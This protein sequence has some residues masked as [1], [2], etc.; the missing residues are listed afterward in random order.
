VVVCGRVADPSL[1]VGPIMAHYGGHWDEWDRLGRATMAGHLLECGAQVTGGYFADP[2]SKDVDGLDDVGFPILEIDASGDC[3][4]TKAAGTGGVVDE[5]TVKEQLLY[6]IHDPAAYL[7]PDVVADIR[8]AEVH[9]VG[10]DRVSLRGVRGHARPGTLKVTACREGGWQGEGEIS[11]AGPGAEARARLAGDVLRKRL[12][13]L[14]VRVDLIGALS[15]F[16]DDGGE[17]LARTPIGDGH[18]VRVRVAARHADRQQ[19]QRVAREGLALY[20]C[21]PAGGGGVRTNVSPRLETR[22]CFVS[23]DAVRPSWRFVS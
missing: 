4:V 7:T 23:R 11:Y 19:A 14:S 3:V 22:S 2:G 1:A 18:D 10:R 6:E 20:T 21:G 8:E 17:M 16:A 12:K 15:L 9:A 5:R 13:G